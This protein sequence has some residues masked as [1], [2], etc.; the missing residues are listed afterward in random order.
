MGL[1]NKSNLRSTEVIKSIF[2]GGVVAG[3][4]DITVAVITTLAS[5]GRP[6][7]MLQGIAFALIG[8]SAFKAGWATALLGLLCH[9]VIA[10]GAAAAYVVVSRK[11]SVMLREP[12]VCGLLYG[13]PVYLVTNFIIVPLSRIGRALPLSPV[14]VTVGLIV[15]TAGVGLPIAIAARRFATIASSPPWQ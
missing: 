12:V 14:G 13:V 10:F 4:I 8:P 11:L 15:M 7:R 9:F 2:I 3:A 5:G 1:P 6:M